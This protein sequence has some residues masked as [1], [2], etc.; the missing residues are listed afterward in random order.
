MILSYDFFICKADRWVPHIVLK[1]LI[2]F[3]MSVSARILMKKVDRRTARF[4]T[5]YDNAM[6]IFVQ[7]VIHFSFDLAA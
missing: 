6:T 7:L 1:V 4:W 2:F 5:Q 3:I